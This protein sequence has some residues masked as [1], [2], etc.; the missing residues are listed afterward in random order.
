MK[1]TAWT[2]NEQPEPS[3]LVLKQQELPDPEPD[4]VLVANKAVALNPVDWKVL[5]S[6]TLGWK[7]GHIPGVD[8]S[9]VV[10]SC[11]AN[12]KI[13]IGTRV[14]YHQNLQSN[15]SFATHTLV[16]TKALLQLPDSV[17]FSSSAAVPCPGLTAWQALAKFPDSPERDVLVIGGGSA[18]GTYL[19]Q[20]ALKRNYRV[21]T[22]ASSRHHDA[23]LKAGVAG[24]FDYRDASWH[25]KLSSALEGRALYAAIDNIGEASARALAPLIGYNGH[26]VCIAG[27]LNTPALPAFTTVIS[28]HEVALGAI[29]QHGA[30]VNWEIFRASGNELLSLIGSGDMRPPQIV[31]FQFDR[32][33]DAL[34]ALKSGTQQGKLIAEL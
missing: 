5:R 13:P 18:T 10:V 25:S 3:A 1:I 34:A 32:L 2:W 20:L 24:V 22:T 12:V 15:G 27:R 6:T 23:L 4:E 26:L 30:D 14:A 31:K 7:P 19:I 17:S 28:L 33:S 8:A 16:A 29:Y 11:G 9:G 21:W